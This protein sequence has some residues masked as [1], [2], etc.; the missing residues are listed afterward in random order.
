MAATQQT[1]VEPQTPGQMARVYR[2][3]ERGPQ[4]I[5]PVTLMVEVDGEPLQI[6]V[7]NGLH[8]GFV[9]TTT[10]EYDGQHFRF[11]Q[12]RHPAEGW[13]AW[14]ERQQ[15]ELDRFDQHLDAE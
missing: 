1:G 8:R 14:I 6:G 15:R 2:E 3:M 11:V 9:Y 12:S 5:V 13:G 7:L 4:T 10:F